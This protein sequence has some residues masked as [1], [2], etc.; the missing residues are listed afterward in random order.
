MAQ[1]RRGPHW[2]WW[3]LIPLLAVG[4]SAWLL[5]SALAGQGINVVVEL[6]HG[7]GLK[8]GDALRYRGIPVGTVRAL[9]LTDDLAAVLAEVRLDPDAKGLAQEGSQFWVVRPQVDISGASGLGT[10]IGANYLGVIPGHGPFQDRFMGL[11]EP[12]LMAVLDAGGLELTLVTTQQGGLRAGAPISY[13]QVVI[14]KV[15]A[16]DLAPDASAV[17]LRAYVEPRYAPLIREGTR[18]WKVGGAHLRAGFTGI[19]LDLDPVSTLILGGVT[20]AIPPDPGPPVAQGRRFRL[21]D[22]PEQEW[23]DWLPFM[24]L[25][26][27]DASRPH[28][29]ALELSWRYKQYWYLTGE[30]H[31]RGWG[32]PVKGG[33][34]GPEDLLQPPDGAL[35]DG[36]ELTVGGQQAKPESARPFAPGLALLPLKPNPPVWPADPTPPLR[37]AEDLLII[38]DPARP[39]RYVA[40][41]RLALQDRVWRIAAEVPFDANWHGASVVSDHDGRLVGLLL[42]DDS[43]ARI[44]ELV[45]ESPPHPRPAPKQG[46]GS[47]WWQRM[48]G[49]P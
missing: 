24:A 26:S 36:L 3:W 22:E 45:S 42:V 16:V 39:M 19:S 35:Q 13:R 11:D 15:L 37:Q 20:L 17:E 40:A 25:E 34:L 12:P 14:G 48:F 21:H 33:V 49:Q 32:L 31:R 27:S 1:V 10:I 18:F 46:D 38:A 47:S 28:P 7:H 44:A 8:P 30:G 4:L 23:L 43:G 6:P 41:D 2:P 9:R 5:L 29:V